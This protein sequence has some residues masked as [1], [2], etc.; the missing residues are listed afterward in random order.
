MKGL[1]VKRVRKVKEGTLIA[2][3]DIGLTTNIGYCTTLDGRDIKPFRFD[4]TKEGFEKFWCTTMASKNGFGCDEVVVGYESP[5]LMPNPS[6]IILRINRSKSSRST[7][8]T[9]RR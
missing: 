3:V 8:C 5:A 2:T 9:R 1:R 4:N 6:F 7:P